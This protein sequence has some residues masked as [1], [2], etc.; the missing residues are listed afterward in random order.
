MSSVRSIA[1]K[2]SA[3]KIILR[4]LQVLLVNLDPFAFDEREP[5]PACLYALQLAPFF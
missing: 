5:N 1:A 4:H 2:F 3:E